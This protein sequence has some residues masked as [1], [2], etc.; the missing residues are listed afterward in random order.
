VDSRRYH[1]RDVGDDWVVGLCEEV[2]ASHT[3]ESR[4]F[5]R[6]DGLGFKAK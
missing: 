1:I 2:Q 3:D 4:R 6:S 5:I